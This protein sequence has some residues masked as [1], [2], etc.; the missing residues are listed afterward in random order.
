MANDNKKDVADKKPQ[1][2]EEVKIDKK[3]LEKLMAIADMV[4]NMQLEMETLREAADQNKLDSIERRRNQGKLVKEVGIS[5]M[6]GKYI[7]AWKSKQDDVYRDTNGNLVE[8]QTVECFFDVKKGEKED[9]KVMTLRNFYLFKEMQKA[10]VIG[11]TKTNEGNIIYDVQF[12]NGRELK[13]DAT[14]VN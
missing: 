12:K 3:S 13:I 2:V 14:F 11:E 8:K 1:A 9:S 6:D 5:M 10:E 7:I 4:P